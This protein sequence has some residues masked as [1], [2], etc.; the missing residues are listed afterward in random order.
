MEAIIIHPKSEEQF[1]VFEHMAKVLK[2]P[3]QKINSKHNLEYEALL[4]E[5]FQQA[6]DGKTVKIRA[7]ELWK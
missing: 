6:K 4:K 5:S 3:F 1:Q 2:V 7:E